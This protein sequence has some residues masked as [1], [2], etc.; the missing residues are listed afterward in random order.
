VVSSD[1]SISELMARL[2]GGDQQA[3]QQLFTLL[4]PE[5]RRLAAVRMSR[6][7]AGHTWQPT[8]L[9]NEL[10]LELLKIK[11]LKGGESPEKEKEA[12]FRLSAFLMRRL[13]IHH[14][15]PL[16]R[17]AQKVDLDEADLSGEPSN[18]SLAE[19]ENVLERLGAVNPA[20]RAVVEMRVFEGHTAAEIAAHLGCSVKTVNRHWAFAQHWLHEA[21][22]G[23]ALPGAAQ[24]GLSARN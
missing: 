23:S 8:A 3:V 18:E 19:I 2:R 10:Y 17:S 24:V 9:V 20:L 21:L 22:S 16:Y 7:P 1:K 12:F 4:Y 14:S 13:L 15:R 5:L 6:E 11:S